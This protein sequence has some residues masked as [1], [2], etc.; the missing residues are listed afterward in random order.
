MNDDRT[1]KES[2]KHLAG[3]HSQ[4]IVLS[5]DAEINS[6][7]IPTRTA[8]VTEIGAQANSYDVRLMG[9]VDDGI[10]LLPTE[11]STVTVIRPLFSDPYISCYGGLDGIVLMGGDLGGMVKVL[12]A[13]ASWNRIEKDVNNLKTLISNWTPISGDGGAALK[14]VLLSWFSSKI[15]LTKQEDIENT[16]IKQG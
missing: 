1:I 16:N 8:N 10:L 7:D 9:S 5:V 3:T 15:P 13:L 4:D 12:Q 6:Y 11:G 14:T 2:I